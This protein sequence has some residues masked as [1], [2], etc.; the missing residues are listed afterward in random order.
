MSDR[1]HRRYPRFPSTLPVGVSM[2]QVVASESRYLNNISEGGLAF[3]AMMPIEIGTVVEVAIPV[4]QPLLRAAARVA[5]CRQNGPE[6]AVG[7]EFIDDNPQF[8]RRLVDMVRQI[9]AYRQQAAEQG[10]QLNAQQATLEWIERHGRQF[11][12]RN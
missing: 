4:N 1:D 7:V 8:R 12:D 6:Y 2:A 5:W 10:R 9:E 11:V 3:N